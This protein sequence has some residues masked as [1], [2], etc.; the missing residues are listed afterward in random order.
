MQQKSEITFLTV[1]EKERLLAEAERAA[2]KDMYRPM[3]VDD[4]DDDLLGFQ[5]YPQHLLGSTSA[6]LLQD[7]YVLQQTE[8]ESAFSTESNAPLVLKKELHDAA[9]AFDRPPTQLESE[10]IE[11]RN[12][13]YPFQSGFEFKLVRSLVNSGASNKDLNLLFN[14]GLLGNAIS[15]WEDENG[16]T[17]SVKSIH[18]MKTVLAKLDNV[19]DI[20]WWSTMKKKVSS[21]EDIKEVTVWYRD[22]IKVVEALLNQKGLENDYV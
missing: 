6:G 7:G 2:L 5:T 15:P 16:L 21:R 22:P 17:S 19:F 9:A 13:W 11:S 10:Y 12:F 4:D 1:L 14:E 18:K 3:T 8:N 20:K